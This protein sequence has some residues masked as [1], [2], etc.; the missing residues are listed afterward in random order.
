MPI[1]S[2]LYRAK[3]SHTLTAIQDMFNLN[4]DPEQ[5]HIVPLNEFSFGYR[6]RGEYDNTVSVDE[7]GI[8]HGYEPVAGA[9]NG[10]MERSS[11]FPNVWFF[12]GSCV[13]ETDDFTYFTMPVIHGGKLVAKRRKIR[14]HEI[15]EDAV[16]PVPT[17]TS[18]EEYKKSYLGREEQRIGELE[19]K[20]R[21][22]IMESLTV[23]KIDG[24]KVLPVLCNETGN[25]H[26]FTGY[27][28]KVDVIVE[29]AYGHESIA[30]LYMAGLYRIGIVGEESFLVKSDYVKPGESGI[31]KVR[32]TP[33]RAEI[34]RIEEIP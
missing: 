1:R 30:S 19:Q 4:Y 3:W 9:L 18:L 33:Y 31:F 25:I 16:F 12:M 17:G 23:L 27:V 11:D 20:A 22:E 10:V 14:Y 29:A 13:E 5:Q 6:V 24:K 8:F 7:D 26:E 15:K 32:A 34:E 21:R 28:G 2:V